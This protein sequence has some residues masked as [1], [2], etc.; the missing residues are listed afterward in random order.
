MDGTRRLMSR[1]SAVHFLLQQY[2]LFIPFKMR[3]VNLTLAIPCRLN[4][5]DQDGIDRVGK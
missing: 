2:W 1:N 3:G 5:S 4:G